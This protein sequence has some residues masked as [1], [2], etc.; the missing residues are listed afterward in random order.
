MKRVGL[1][2]LLL[3]LL[4]PP[5]TSQVPDDKLIVSGQRIGKWTLEMTLDDLVRINGPAE[6]GVPPQELTIVVRR[7]T[8][9]AWPGDNPLTAATRDGRR[10]LVLILA[11]DGPKESVART[12]KTEKGIAIGYSRSD[13]LAAYGSPA[14]APGGLSI[15]DEFGITFGIR[16]E[17]VA[18][19]M[20]F[21]PRTGASIW[22]L[23]ATTQAPAPTPSPTPRDGNGY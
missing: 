23:Q 6:C 22:R 18:S 1:F 21:L 13:M 4:A 15:Y 7:D 20:V 2:L 10:V 19:I 8:L 9:C 17:R 14:G 5:A 11:G 16:S 3:L 12:F